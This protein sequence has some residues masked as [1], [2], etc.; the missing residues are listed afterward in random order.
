MVS[1][2]GKTQIKGTLDLFNVIFI[3]LLN[4]VVLKFQLYKV[5]KFSRS[6]VLYCAYS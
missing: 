1:R 4:Y 2:S 3:I 6:A 5:N